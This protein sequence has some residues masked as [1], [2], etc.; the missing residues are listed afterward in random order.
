VRKPSAAELRLGNLRR[1][2]DA[3]DDPATRSAILYHM[4]LVYEHELRQSNEAL[5]SYREARRHGTGFDPAGIAELRIQERTADARTV[6]SLLEE[7]ARDARHP[8]ARG[9]ALVDLALRSSEWASILRDALEQSPEPSVPAL[10]L[11]WLADRNGDHDALRDALR[12]QA[13]AA[14]E[15]SL[16]ASLWLDHALAENEAGD[17]DAALAS[18][19]LAAESEALAWPARSLQRSL[20]QQHQ[21]LDAWETASVAMARQLEGDVPL[22]PLDLSTPIEEQ[23]PLAA[24]LWREAASIRLAREGDS[25]KARAYLEAALRQTPNDAELRW[26]LLQLGEK[27]GDADAVRE[28]AKWFHSTAPGDPRLPAY[29]IRAS[30][31]RRDADA[32]DALRDIAERYPESAY[33]QAVFDLTLFTTGSVDERV[34]RLQARAADLE[35]EARALL[36]WRAAR[37]LAEDD[38]PEAAESLFSESAE[39]AT[40]WRTDILRDALRAAVEARHADAILA[41]ADALADAD[42]EPADRAFV[43]YCRYAVARRLHGSAD[44]SLR[45]LRD[46]LQ[47]PLNHIWAPHVAR[48][49]AAVEGNAALLGEAH[50]LLADLARENSKTEHL[51]SAGAAF[52]ANQQW[53]DAERVVRAALRHSPDDPRVVEALESVLRGAGRP[54][55]VVELAR[56]RARTDDD[57]MRG[58]RA[59]L[60]AGVSAERDGDLEAAGSA[61]RQA[62][63]RLPES[64]S[65]SLAMA[66]LAR[67]RKDM[68][69]LLGA[70]E[71][72]SHIELGGGVPELFALRKADM[73][74]DLEGDSSEASRQYERALEHPATTLSSAVALLSLP[75]ARTTEEQR[76]S[77]AELLV[78]AGVSFEASDNGFGTAYSALRAA[79]G[80]EG[81]TA[82]LAWVELARLAPTDALRAG[83]LL[84]GLREVRLARGEDAI[85]DLFILAQ[86][87][88]DLSA[89]HPEA[90]VAIEEVLAPGDDPELRI[91]ALER[92]L[93]HSTALGRSGLEAARCRALVEGDRGAD[94]VARISE[95]LDERPEDLAVWE[96]LRSAARQAG[97]WSL[98]AQ[99]CERLAPFVEGELRADL[100][101]EAGA[102]RLD[103]LDQQQA[104]E[105]LFRAALEAD[106]SRS[107]AFRR[108]HELLAD[109]EDGEA[110]DAL[111]AE[112]LSQGGSDDR[113]DL[114]YARARLLR[115]FS[116]RPGA[117]E[118]LD[119][120][121]IAEPEHAG[122]LA[123]AAEVHVSLEQWEEAVDCLQRLSKSDIPNEQRRLAHLGAADFLENRLGRLEHALEELR[124]ID[125]LGLA[126]MESRLR[127]ASLEEGFG[128]DQAAID[129]YRAVLLE[130]PTHVR[131]AERLASL[132]KDDERATVLASY[133]AALW[134]RIDGGDLDAALLEALR[135]SAHWQGS[136]ERASA[137]AAVE[138]AI[139]PG[140]ALESGTTDLSHVST[141]AFWDR[142]SDSTIE[143]MV[144]AAG[145]SLSDPRPRGK[146][147]P[148]DSAVA[149]ELQQIS[150][151]FG[152]R[153]ASA[154]AEE[155]IDRTQAFVDRDGAL[156]WFIPSASRD[157]L[158]SVQRFVAGRLA[159]A[160]PRGGAELVDSSPEK[161]AGL[162]AGII[163]AARCSVAPGG[164]TLP[165][166]PVKLRR[167]SRKAVRDV[168][169]D[170]AIAPA[171]LLD[172]A[173]RFQRS[174]DRAGLVASGDIAAS[175]AVVFGSTPTMTA[176]RTSPRA[177]DL[178]RFWAA[179]DSP[180]WGTHG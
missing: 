15:P 99:A 172:A 167:A 4:G 175:W 124:A 20:A 111:I 146:K 14:S 10:L 170:R 92:K 65:A 94:A 107:I 67:R 157:G 152:A 31:G 129:A 137:I 144:R 138:D 148:A 128:N 11:E 35:G 34:D 104:A 89:Q 95:E 131:A 66:E 171:S 108:L 155:S 180:L 39:I 114:L 49:R 41:R 30:L 63:A 73:L 26:Q 122:A 1:E 23:L 84:H 69:A 164:P 12:A 88:G 33:A 22:D 125:A 71:T 154:S 156:Q 145:P 121:F 60:R 98:V 169:G 96:T 153:F 5:D 109:R 3:E 68:G 8:A 117:L 100:L 53:T 174:A 86:E 82:G 58:E 119:E 141:A 165:A 79:L 140:G 106:P 178:L 7:L 168:L 19:D 87:S 42:L 116:D 21:R 9:A 132:M 72:L 110:L 2:L 118:A 176:L 120:L 54:D 85:D 113:P 115:G 78:D 76:A 91:A 80:R 133:E 29:V 51:L 46:A 139:E 50:E 142:E 55:A 44:E 38:S 134:A 160:A 32:L 159:W 28:A 166:V 151:G 17:V 97:Q 25:S 81:S 47:D 90:A 158:D 27:S 105:D 161:A 136:F 70:Y 64:A 177:L 59:L 18:L 6:A 150:E 37:L 62:L 74:R 143:E 83:T 77:A 52:A 36:L 24:W 147:L 127:V 173:R 162:L 135:K 93:Q 48:A 163:L 123:L 13:E 75:L 130:D 40:P 102:V 101:E 149:R 179:A 126:D 43:A 61:Y 57:I 103:H 56:E 112:R 16:R 45:I